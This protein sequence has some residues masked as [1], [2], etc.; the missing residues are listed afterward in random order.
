MPPGLVTSTPVRICLRTPNTFICCLSCF[1]LNM[2]VWPQVV[3]DG[4][5]VLSRP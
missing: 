3:D 5:G 4:F 1:G 2:I